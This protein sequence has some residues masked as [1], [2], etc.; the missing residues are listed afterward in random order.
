MNAKEF[1][2]KYEVGAH[3]IRQTNREFGPVVRT[4]GKANEFR[5]GAIVE[6]N[7][8]PY[9]VRINTLTPAM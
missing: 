6:I 7:V 2:R 5:C 9:F 3:F 8:I 1:N 4:V